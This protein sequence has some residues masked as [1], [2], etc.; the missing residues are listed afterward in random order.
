MSEDPLLGRQLANFQIERVIGRGGMA[1][2]YYG[3]DVKLERPVAIKVIDTQ[4]RDKPTYAER[5]IREA[6][7]VAGWRHEH[8]IQIHYA[9]DEDD[10]YYFVMEYIAGSDLRQLMAQYTEQGD[11]IPSAEVLRIGR[12]VAQALD[13]AHAQNVIHRDVKPSN[14]MVAKDNR[15]VLTDFGLALDV[16]Q[17]SLGEVFGSSQYIAPEQARRSADAV[18][19][20]DLY[21]LGVILYEMLVGK[22][23]FDDPSPTAVALQHLN[24]PP[25]SPRALN[26]DLSAGVEAVL[27]KALKKSPEE[28]Y[29]TGQNLLDALEAALQIPQPQ[30]E[31]TE[32][33]E[34]SQTDKDEVKT[35][36]EESTASTDTAQDTATV[37]IGEMAEITGTSSPAPTT[38][39]DDLIGQ[40][41]DEYRLEELLGRGGMA[42]VYRALDVNLQRYVAIK[43]IDAP[44]RADS[45]A[46]ARFERTRFEREAQAIAQLEHPHIVRIYRY[47]KTNDLLYMAMQYIEGANLDSV[48]E[49]YCADNEFMPPEDVSR[50][51]REICEAL[52]HAHSKD[53]IH[54]DIKPSNIML[55]QEGR[56]ILT[57]FGLALLIELGTKGEIFGSP[58]YIAPEQAISSAGVVPQSDFYSV[59]IILYEM[60]TGQVPFS[61]DTPIDVA[62]LHM[63]EPPRP[64]RELR[65]EISPEVEVVILKLLAKEPNE[66]YPNG[67]AVA[68]ALDQ[69]LQATTTSKESPTTIPSPSAPIPVRIAA[70][71]AEN[72]LP[73]LPITPVEQ[74]KPAE[75][76]SP[77]ESEIESKK[78]PLPPIPA[79]VALRAS[80]PTQRM[81]ESE[82]EPPAAP[83]TEPL[84]AKVVPGKSS[85]QRP[86]LYITLLG[87]MALVIILI[88]L[89]IAFGIWFYGVGSIW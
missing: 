78:T 51:I 54:R 69:A 42:R 16:E 14:V 48:L 18:P 84:V 86:L 59:G 80:Q 65:P 63:S 22:V 89:A 37:S 21:S 55:D 2:V 6:K 60:F 17:G 20:S 32:Q 67:A 64:P 3:R 72:P 15:V 75:T 36:T 83:S 47:G 9:D 44:F 5:F 81:S 79:A 39:D 8:I 62:M 28:R 4:H 27:L 52:D 74:S 38:T 23:P 31:I 82:F 77:E 29:Q 61:A 34:T 46:A 40:Q 12:A 70:E 45:E 19:Q 88:I 13:Y 53:V 43:V 73:P 10:L 71:L 30:A 76:P 87:V 57:D 58:Y 66:R 11:L 1:T 24:N 49:T 7:T 33:T 41:L 56:A 26:P 35:R 50:I 68:E 85:T 25:P